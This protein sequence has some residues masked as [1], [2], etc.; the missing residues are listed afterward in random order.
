M[1]HILILEDDLSYRKMLSQRLSKYGRVFEAE[2]LEAGLKALDAGHIDFAVVDLDLK[3]K[4]DGLKF[5][6]ASKNKDLNAIVLSS[7]EEQNIIEKAFELGAIGFLNKWDFDQHLDGSIEEFLSKSRS[8]DCSS[9]YETVNQDLITKLSNT[10]KLFEKTK[11]SLLIEGE[12]G[13]GKGK[14]AK[15]L[16][17]K[18]VFVHVNLSEF[19]KGT[20]ESELFGHV[21][22]A[23]TGALSDKEGL[24]KKADGGVLFL[25]EIGTLSLELQK[26]LLRVIEEKVFYPVGSSK[27]VSS[28]FR[29]ITATC[30]DLKTLTENG[31][32]RE[33]FYYRISGLKITI[34]ALRDRA[35][36][37]KDLLSNINKDSC[38]KLYLSSEIKGYLTSYPWYGN[39]REL[40]SFFEKIRMLSRGR[41]TIEE[42]EKLLTSEVKNKKEDLTF[43]MKNTIKE[44]GL[45]FF[46]NS[47]EIEALKWAKLKTGG[48]INESV[49]LLNIS[50]SLYYR[51][52]NNA[53]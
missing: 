31:E 40:L 22:G 24:F 20:L 6:E 43:E 12:T 50:K 49:R 13:V 8:F 53:N 2:D 29:I 7:H 21:K 9:Y 39:Y 41:V 14:L 34:P 15:A 27:P 11:Q 30:D 48:R 42:V 37:I 25:D 35:D 23:F 26:K 3:N 36:D 10:I 51:I 52:A 47:L 28:N 5:L 46:L 18:Q 17:R 33:D 16:S 19:S 44:K 1:K 38:K 4:L 45:K 32:F